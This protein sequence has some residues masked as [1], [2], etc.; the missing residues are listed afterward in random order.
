MNQSFET[1]HPRRDRCTLTVHSPERSVPRRQGRDTAWT[2]VKVV[3]PRLRSVSSCSAASSSSC[4][5][6][7]LT[8]CNRCVRREALNWSVGAGRGG[9]AEARALALRS[10]HPG[11]D[12]HV[13]GA[14]ARNRRLSCL[15]RRPKRLEDQL[16]QTLGGL[17]R[18]VEVPGRRVGIPCG[19]EIRSSRKSAISTARPNFCT[20]R[21]RKS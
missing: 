19:A 18:W 8:S 20:R 4:R 21:G 10:A 11:R 15:R 12:D 14:R 16:D 1:P 9:R 2:S 13:A 5:S 6:D 3:P 17:G 7:S